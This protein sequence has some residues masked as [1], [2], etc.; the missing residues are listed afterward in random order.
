MRKMEK[1]P[2]THM[3]RR[4]RPQQSERR[5]EQTNAD[6]EM[7]GGKSLWIKGIAPVSNKRFLRADGSSSVKPVDQ[8]NA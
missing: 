1:R 8:Q 7:L 6:S 5:T 3:Q 4:R 2:A